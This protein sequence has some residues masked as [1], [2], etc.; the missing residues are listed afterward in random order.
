[1]PI[2]DNRSNARENHGSRPWQSPGLLI[3]LVVCFRNLE[4]MDT[5]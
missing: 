3:R 4:E 1:M 5:S 2:M